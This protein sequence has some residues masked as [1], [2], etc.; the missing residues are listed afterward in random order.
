MLVSKNLKKMKTRISAVLLLLSFFSSSQNLVPNHSFEHGR[1]DGFDGN[2]GEGKLEG[3]EDWKP[4]GSSDWYVNGDRFTMQ[5]EPVQRHVVS[6]TGTYCIGFGPC[7]GAQI[8]LAPVNNQPLSNRIYGYKLSFDFMPRNSI[9]SEL[10]VYIMDD[11]FIGNN[12]VSCEDPGINHLIH[13]TIPISSQDHDPNVW[14]HFEGEMEHATILENFNHL[15]I[16]GENMMGTYED[17]DFG[18][19]KYL[20]VDN[21]KLEKIPYCDHPCAGNKD[22]EAVAIMWNPNDNSQT[23]L[24]IAEGFSMNAITDFNPLIVNLKRA[25]YVEFLVVDRWGNQETWEYFN[26][27]G[28]T[29]LDYDLSTSSDQ[30]L[31]DFLRIHDDV[32]T[33]MWDGTI[34]GNLVAGEFVYTMRVTVDNC[35]MYPKI[36]HS[37]KVAS[38]DYSPDV[39]DFKWTTLIH[40]DCCETGGFVTTSSSEGSLFFEGTLSTSSGY[41]VSP[42]EN[43]RHSSST[44]IDIIPGFEAPYNA[45]YT[46]LIKECGESTE[47]NKLQS[48]FTTSIDVVNVFPNPAS[49]N[50][51][52]KSKDSIKLVTLWDTKGNVVLSES[53]TN[54]ELTYLVNVS[55]LSPGFY[56]LECVLLNGLIERKQI[57]I[58][59]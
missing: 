33:L 23:E 47:S 11:E 25:N 50:F 59:R 13:Y 35:V 26:P 16:K 58:Q 20:L 41:T 28:L 53:I 7:E 24:E 44:S 18:S 42:G 3:L 34:N 48:Q 31:T 40:D 54:Y 19:N 27:N 14:N 51:T 57:I 30:V 4:F 21:V 12:L 49:N 32:F 36:E 8:K 29:N 17:H 43:I 38:F 46:A 55:Q 45:S 52:V 37:T 15:A 2:M 39:P 1:D 9:N 22:S 5:W 56:I 6:K 10:N